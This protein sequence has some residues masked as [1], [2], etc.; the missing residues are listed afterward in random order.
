MLPEE[1]LTAQNTSCLNKLAS[2][3]QLVIVTNQSTVAAIVVANCTLSGR[4]ASTHERIVL[5]MQQPLL[6]LFF[7]FY[8]LYLQKLYFLGAPVENSFFCPPSDSEEIVNLIRRQKC[9]STD[10]MNIPVF[11][12]KILAPLIAP[13]VSMLFITHC[14]KVFFQNALKRLKLFLFSNLVTQIRLR[15]IDLFPCFPSC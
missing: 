11:M 12:Y 4:L 5:R 2:I 8:T 3:Q 6:C 9:K 7:Y 14:L 15:I 1:S 10:L 13:T